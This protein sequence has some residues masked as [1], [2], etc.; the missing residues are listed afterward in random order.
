[1]LGD[2]KG[3]RKARDLQSSEEILTE[4]QE[5]RDIFTF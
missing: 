4:L 2:L 5:L 3:T 1:M